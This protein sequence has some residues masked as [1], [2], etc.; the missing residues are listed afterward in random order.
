MRTKQTKMTTRDVQEF[1]REQIIRGD[2]VDGI[3]NIKSRNDIFMVDGERQTSVM[4]TEVA[5]WQNMTEEEIYKDNET[6]KANYIRNKK[7]IDLDSIPESV[8]ESIIDVYTKYETVPR[9][10]ILR[11]FVKYRLGNLA[12]DIS[13]F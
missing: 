7:L 10:Q 2:G 1:I 9:K 4:A 11:Y 13:D 6:L 8:V 5:L 12:A 3:P